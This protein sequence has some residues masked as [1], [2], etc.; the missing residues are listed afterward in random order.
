M[1]TEKLLYHYTSGDGL[2]GILSNDSLWATDIF[3]MND[4][5]EF[6][7]FTDLLINKIQHKC[8]CLGDGHQGQWKEEWYNAIER[9]LQGVFASD[10]YVTCFSKRGDSLSQWRG[11]TQSNFGYCLVFDY[12]KI[13][14]LTYKQN[15]FMVHCIYSEEEQSSIAKEFVEKFISAVVD[16]QNSHVF[17]SQKTMDDIVSE[18]GRKY[19]TV[20][21]S[22]ASSI[23]NSAFED[24]NEVRVI[25]LCI[26]NDVKFR[27]GGSFV[28]PYQEFPLELSKPDSPLKEIIIGPTPNPNLALKSV[29]M[30]LDQ[31]GWKVSVRNTI[32]PYR[33]W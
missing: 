21:Q 6:T 28:I 1:T 16:N 24:E 19:I 17:E 3:F 8:N 2:I 30:M 10:I 26:K 9:Y 32:V 20:I 5:R 12:D 13:S 4:K 18:I 7:Q 23:K 33:T 25:M 22:L 11:Y 14:E 31:K 15:S 29:Q 27:P